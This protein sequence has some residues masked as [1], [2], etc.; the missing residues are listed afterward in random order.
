MGIHETP[1]QRKMLDWLNALPGACFTRTP[2]VRVR[3]GARWIH[4]GEVGWPDI[5]GAYRGV[6]V[7]V[8]VKAPGGTTDKDREEKQHKKR[9]EWREAGG[10][11]I[12]AESMESLAASIG[13][14]EKRILF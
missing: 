1:L 10:V 13:D 14:L 9:E 11:A 2:V 7:V 5:T 8:E 12:V 3:K 6:P 4:A